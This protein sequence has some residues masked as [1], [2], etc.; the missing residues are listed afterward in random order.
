MP[1]LKHKPGAKTFLVL[2]STLLILVKAPPYQPV[3]CRMDKSEASPT[4]TEE[5]C[6]ED[7][8]L[9]NK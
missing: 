6:L 5:P 3:S 2:K 9:K 1:S 8:D 4:P 7:M